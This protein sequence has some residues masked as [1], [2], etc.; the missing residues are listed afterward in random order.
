[1]GGSH[2]CGSFP[3]ELP[4]DNVTGARYF[5][6]SSTGILLHYRSRAADAS[7]VARGTIYVV[8]GYAEH[9][10]RHETI[11]SALSSAGFH[12]HALDLP[13]HGQS[14]GDR[15]YI[16]SL[17]DVVAD[18]L[19]LCERVAPPAPGLP[20]FILGHSFGGLVSLRV[21]QSAAGKKLFKGAILSAPLL[22]ADP[23]VDTALNRF[24]AMTLSDLLPKLPVTPLDARKL[25]TDSV[26]VEAYRRDPLVYHGNVRVRFGAE[27]IRGMEAAFRDVPDMTVPVFILHGTADQVCPIEGSRK[28]VAQTPS[29]AKIKEYAGAFHELLLEPSATK[30]A[31]RDI[32]SWLD[33]RIAMLSVS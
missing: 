6:A 16:T 5:K 26:V 22:K 15:A 20:A 32:L 19:E 14:H 28:L 2:S 12:V 4:P 3:H 24:L 29:L 17:S 8:H 10:G 13:G 33:D 21:S 23:A 1:M 31:T 27:C 18:V 7:V 25:C 9:L 11:I 30:E